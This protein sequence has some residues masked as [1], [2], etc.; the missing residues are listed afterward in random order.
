MSPCHTRV[1]TT[2]M[3]KLSYVIFLNFYP[4]RSVIVNIM[5]LRLCFVVHYP[6][7]TKYIRFEEIKNKK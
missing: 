1:D 3:I 5:C 4:R 7:H 6:S 2:L